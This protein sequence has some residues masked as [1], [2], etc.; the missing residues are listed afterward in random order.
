MSKKDLINTYTIGVKRYSDKFT[1]ICYYS[2]DLEDSFKILKSFTEKWNIFWKDYNELFIRKEQI[3]VS[4]YLY[5][6]CDNISENEA[7][8]LAIDHGFQLEDV[9]KWLPQK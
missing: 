6:N 8:C 2:H 4:R 1:G 3:E 9:W 5:C 7:R